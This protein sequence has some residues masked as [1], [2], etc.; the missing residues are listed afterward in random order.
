MKNPPT[1]L[2]FGL[3]SLTTLTL[4]SAA[5]A[6]ACVALK[7]ENSAG[8]AERNRAV[9]KSRGDHDEIGSNKFTLPGPQRERDLL[10][11]AEQ[12]H[13][14]RAYPADDIAFELTLNAQAAFRN[15]EARTAN[16]EAMAPSAAAVRPPWQLIGPTKAKDPAILSFSGANY[17][18]SGRITAMAIAPDCSSTCRVWVAA[19]GGG[20]WRTDNAL[21]DNVKWTFVSRSFS[22]NAIGT[23][24]YD[25]SSNALYAG[26][27]EPNASGDSEAGLGLFKSTDGGDTWAHLPAV[28]TTSISGP[29]TGDAFQNR[30][31]NSVV[32]DPLNP[33]ILYVGSASAV[34][35]VASVSG[36]AENPPAPL[37]ARGVYKSTDGGQ[38]FTHLNSDSSGLPFVYRGVTDVK[39]D[40]RDRNTLYAG[41]FG[42][43]VFRSKDAGVSWTQIFAPINPDNPAAIE[44][45]SIEVVKLPNGHTRMYL[46]AG[47]NGTFTARLYRSDLVESGKPSF[48][49]LTTVENAGY[50]RTQCW[51]DNVV[52]SPPGS[53]NTVLLGGAYDYEHYGNRSNGRAFI[54]STNSGLSFTDMTWDAT[55][56]PT[57]AGSCCQPNAI[58][59]NGMHPDS[60]AVVRVPGTES[61]IFGSD[62]GLVR[63]A[64]QF[65]DISAQCYDRQLASSD[66]LI[67]CRQLL[68]RVPKVLFN[69]NSGLSTLQFQSLSLASDDP[70]HVQGG[71][72]DNGTF[73]S[74]GG[75]LMWP[76]IIYGDGG[77]SGFKNDNSAV[78]FNTFTGQANDANFRNGDPSKWVIISAP[79]LSSPEGAYFYPPIIADPHPGNA[80][81]IFQGSYSVWRTQDW[82]GD[83]TTLE[84]NCQEFTTS[85][86][87]PGCGDFV[88]IGPAGKTDLTS[89][90]Y[91]LKRVGAA[92]AA[93][94]RAGSDAGTLWAATGTGRVFISKNANDADPSAVIFK[95][96]DSQAA[97]DP[98]RFVSSIVID[99][100][101]PNHGWLSYSGYNSHTPD[102]PGHVFEVTYNPGTG[103]ATWKNLDG[104]SGPMGDLPVTGLVRDDQNGDLYAST[105]FGVLR[106]ANG[107][108]S[109]T[110]AGRGLPMVEV[111]GLTINSQARVLYAATHGRSAWKLTLP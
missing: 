16:D 79:I 92:V 31:I 110:V 47:D 83:K 32:V 111:A 37:P 82:G 71:T 67:I 30:A 34:R 101:D 22:T 9:T 46:G 85:S 41:Q 99:P 29:Y 43:G 49:D 6:M 89:K 59:P 60:H 102:Q 68:S 42:Q 24:T 74:S 97:K 3:R 63:S 11:A 70:T 73:E 20:I 19:A 75:A 96:I 86:V 55:T 108:T 106:L 52:Y 35:G 66:D 36:A 50:C 5:A 62:G 45:D 98:E 56:N 84:K 57:P 88:P 15:V 105:D 44:R 109:W 4:I 103:K 65:A 28:T 91:G 39:I 12:A 13:A 100:A 8:F 1:H 58:A 40:P 80:G 104:D 95:R 61:Y 48:N 69:L 90:K 81:S 33:N 18:T 78:R 17:T 2:R 10:S 25:I 54:Y 93:I 94:Q 76:Q 64:S 38:T 77:Q 21:A 107:A 27:G 7:P 14:I 53:P 26:T 72:Q 87:Q 23:L 51:Y